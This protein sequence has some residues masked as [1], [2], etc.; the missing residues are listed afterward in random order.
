MRVE[1]EVPNTGKTSDGLLHQSESVE[2]RN[3]GRIAQV[4]QEDVRSV[5][6]GLRVR[7]KKTP[8]D[9]RIQEPAIALLIRHQTSRSARQVDV[10]WTPE[11][12]IQGVDRR[13][14]VQADERID[15]G[16]LDQRLSGLDIVSIGD[17]V[18]P[19]ARVDIDEDV[20]GAK[21]LDDERANQV[22]ERTAGL[23]LKDD[24]EQLE[25]GIAEADFEIPKARFPPITAL[26]FPLRL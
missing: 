11:S 3:D 15:T 5:Q 7:T 4:R 8:I 1:V 12:Q 10:G 21:R 6:R 14:P 17:L 25:S 18:P 13:V 19:L 24:A 9:E 26:M 2:G 22:V 16:R 20:V 23:M